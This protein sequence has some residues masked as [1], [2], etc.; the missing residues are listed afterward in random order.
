MARIAELF[1]RYYVM[2]IE[3]SK[4]NEFAVVQVKQSEEAANA[5]NGSLIEGQKMVVLTNAQYLTRKAE[6]T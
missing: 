5:L 4:N 1:Q 6:L 3:M 2:H